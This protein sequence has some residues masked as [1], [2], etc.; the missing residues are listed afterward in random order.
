MGKSVRKSHPW[1]GRTAVP[2]LQETPGDPQSCVLVT[3]VLAENTSGQEDIDLRTWWVRLEASR[4]IFISLPQD[5]MSSGALCLEG[6]EAFPSLKKLKTKQNKKNKQQ[7]QQK[8]F[9]CLNLDI[10]QVQH[11]WW[12]GQPR[13][14]CSRQW[15]MHRGD[16]HLQS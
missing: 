1:G 5:P 2:P 14:T 16:S 8:V 3:S 12:G 9:Q 13:L 15:C 6:G 7:Q 11:V 4:K 10:S